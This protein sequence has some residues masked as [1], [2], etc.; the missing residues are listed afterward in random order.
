MSCRLP[1]LV[2]KRS[3]ARHH[4]ILPSVQAIQ[5]PFYSDFCACVMQKVR[6]HLMNQKHPE[7]RRDKPHATSASPVSTPDSLKQKGRKSFEQSPAT[8]DATEPA[9]DYTGA[10]TDYPPHASPQ[11]HILSGKLQGSESVCL[12]QL[13]KLEV[14]RERESRSERESTRERERERES[15]TERASAKPPSLS[16]SDRQGTRICSRVAEA[17]AATGAA[18]RLRESLPVIT[19]DKLPTCLDSRGCCED[20]RTSGKEAK[21]RVR[22][23]L[24]Q[25]A[26]V[27]E[28][29]HATVI[30]EN[31]LLERKAHPLP[32]PPPPEGS[33]R[34]LGSLHSQTLQGSPTM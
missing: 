5:P 6:N 15:P 8:E 34:P 9:T 31:A 12:D 24:A 16:P 33:S 20:G 26:K 19:T 21:H 13:E 18:T 27:I 3:E 29:Q 23:V 10:A 25:H 1:W 17:G 4:C 14:S 11:L 22:E 28:Q 7:S 32:L 30:E 2:C